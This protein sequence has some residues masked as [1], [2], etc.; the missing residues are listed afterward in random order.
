MTG[1]PSGLTVTLPKALAELKKTVPEGTRIML[2]FDRGGAYPQVFAHWS[3][4]NLLCELGQLSSF[5]Y[6]TVGSFRCSGQTG[7]RSPNATENAFM[8]AFQP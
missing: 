3:L 5:C 6:I 4:S 7:T 8:A 2:G 1:E